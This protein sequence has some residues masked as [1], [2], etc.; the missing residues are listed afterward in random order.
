MI[1][2]ASDDDRN[3]SYLL[4]GDRTRI[5]FGRVQIN[6]NDISSSNQHFFNAILFSGNYNEPSPEVSTCFFLPQFLFLRPRILFRSFQLSTV[7]H[8]NSKVTEAEMIGCK[9]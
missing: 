9:I 1:C 3:D 4:V 2:W 6:E 5:Q 7:S 8:V